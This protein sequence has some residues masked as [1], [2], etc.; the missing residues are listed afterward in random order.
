LRLMIPKAIRKRRPITAL[1]R[2]SAKWA[3]QGAM[4]RLSL[5]WRRSR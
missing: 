2:A 1:R 3:D 4:S 5:G